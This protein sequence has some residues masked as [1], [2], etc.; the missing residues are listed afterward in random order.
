MILSAYVAF[1]AVIIQLCLKERAAKV[2]GQ[3]LSMEISDCCSWA[4]QVLRIEADGGPDRNCT[5]A[6]VQLAYLC[7]A[8]ELDLDQP[9]LLSTAP[10]QS[11]VNPVERVMSVLNLA[12]QG[13]ALATAVSSNELEAKLKGASSI[14]SICKVVQAGAA[15]ASAADAVR[16]ESPKSF[17][18]QYSNAMRVPIKQLEEASGVCTCLLKS[19]CLDAQMWKRAY[20]LVC[21]MGCARI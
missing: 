5:F 15:V 7:L 16:V 19:V 17:A 9:I 20:W 13:L 6:G 3:A 21:N 10:R 1:C 18:Q 11:Y 4:V 2:C 14:K 8:L 12:I